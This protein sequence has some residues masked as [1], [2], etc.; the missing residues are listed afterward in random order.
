MTKLY[1]IR[2]GETVWNVERRMQ[3]HLDSPL[4]ALGEQQA[5][6]LSNALKDVPFDVL[7]SSSSGRTMQ[8]AHIVKGSRD[9]SIHS[10]DDWREMNLGAWEGR[11]SA[12][13]EEFDSDNYH[14]FWH[15]PDLYRPTKGESY[16]DLQARVIPALMLLLKEHTG[17]TIGLVSHTVTLKIIMAYFEG[18]AF[19]DLWNPP[20]FHPT[21]LSLVEMIDNEPNIRLHG[22]T[23]HFQ[24]EAFGF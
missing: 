6:W 22:D 18:R 21:C 11:V 19:T 1:L 8:T 7:Y 23:S 16:D 13:I 4:S 15:T 20:Y 9:L 24:E 12:E 5:T 3:G 10:S 2:H 17:K 14:A